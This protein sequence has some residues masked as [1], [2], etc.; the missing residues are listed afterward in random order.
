M[1]KKA[2]DAM[3]KAELEEYIRLIGIKTKAKSASEMR[4][5]I[6]ERRE[7]VAH[8]TIMGVDVDIPVKHFRSQKVTE[9]WQKANNDADYDNLIAYIVGD[10][11][12]DELIEACTDDT[13]EL[14]VDAYSFVAASIFSSEELKN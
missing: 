4:K 6:E 5:T 12:H 13:G 11:K 9:M 3:T 10:E 14:D 7:R 8:L 1:N 2:L